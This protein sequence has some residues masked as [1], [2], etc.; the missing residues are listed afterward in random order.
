M[1]DARSSRMWTLLGLAALFATVGV[2]SRHRIA[3]PSA[4]ASPVFA[5][6][7][8]R[9]AVA[10]PAP[11]PA[12]SFGALGRP[13]PASW[14]STPSSRRAELDRQLLSSRRRRGM[15]QSVSLQ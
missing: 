7:D 11:I 2:Y 5:D 12:A 10:E 8:L 9:D 13:V 6:A 15:A 4:D 14:F 1:N 3:R